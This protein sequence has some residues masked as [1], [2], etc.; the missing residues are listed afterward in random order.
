MDIK[1]N[2]DMTAIKKKIEEAIMQKDESVLRIFNYV[3]EQCVRNARIQKGYQDRTA[4]L[5]SSIGF[6][7]L[8]DGV[9]V[10]SQFNG[11][12]SKGVTEAKKTA[13]KVALSYPKGYALIV[14]AG[15]KYATYVESKG[16]NVLTT[17]E[18]LAERQVPRLLKEIE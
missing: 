11:E 5:K 3:G 18:Q 2:F 17:A 15:M 6:I 12:K 7:V 16:F 14:V 1:A 8:K 10:N 9:P 13:T 4:N